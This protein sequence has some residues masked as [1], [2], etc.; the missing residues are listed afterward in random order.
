MRD[1]TTNTV[2]LG[3]LEPGRRFYLHNDTIHMQEYV[4]IRKRGDV[5]RVRRIVPAQG[6]GWCWVQAQP[7][8]IWT[9]VHKCTVSRKSKATSPRK[10]DVAF[11]VSRFI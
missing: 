9:A 6:D 10:G 1:T 2:A 11:S 7:P 3:T 5:V 4:V 8:Q